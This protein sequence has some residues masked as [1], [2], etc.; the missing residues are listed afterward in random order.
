MGDHARKFHGNKTRWESDWK[1]GVYRSRDLNG[2]RTNFNFAD[3][4]SGKRYAGNNP[5]IPC[6]WSRLISERRV[7][8]SLRSNRCSVYFILFNEFKSFFWYN[9]FLLFRQFQRLLTCFSFLLISIVNQKLYRYLINNNFNRFSMKIS[10]S[11]ISKVYYS[12]K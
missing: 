4:G 5:V 1:E 3:D 11:K 9:F 6:K 10:K 8:G 7:D 2:T 12:E